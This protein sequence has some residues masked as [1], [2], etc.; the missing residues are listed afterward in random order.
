V[1]LQMVM[2][3]P[4]RRRRKVQREPHEGSH[5][6]VSEQGLRWPR[7]RRTVQPIDWKMLV[8]RNNSR[9]DRVGM[10]LA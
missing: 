10:Y 3:A 1:Y 2:N 5:L 7:L 4:G 9:E 6:S 8:D